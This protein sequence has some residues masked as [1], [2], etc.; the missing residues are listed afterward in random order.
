MCDGKSG[1]K[2]DS[3]QGGVMNSIRALPWKAYFRVAGVVGL[4]TLLALV[5]AYLLGMIFY[6]GPFAQAGWENGLLGLMWLVAMVL[7]FFRIKVW[8]VRVVWWL[9]GLAVV[10]AP[11]LMIRPSNDRNW[12]PE[13]DRTGYASVKGDVVTL[14]NVRNFVHRGREDF[15]E[16]WEVRK[17]HL[18]KLRGL[19]YF[20]SNF[21]GDTLAHPILSFDFGEDGRVC[22][23]VETR[24]EVGEKFTPFG[25]LY[26]MF[27]LQYLFIT[28][29]DCIPLRTNVRGEIVRRYT[30][31]GSLEKIRAMFLSSVKIQNDLAERPRFYNVIRANCTTSLRAQRPKSDRGPLDS[32]LLFNGMLDEYL[33]EQNLLKTE[34]LSFEK[35]RERSIVNKVAQEIQATPDFSNRIRGGDR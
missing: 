1:E 5:A 9:A 33:Y 16:R 3:H 22:L 27:E 7:V 11:W 21:Y 28:E 31:N 35:L 6:N 29:E 20:Q 24:R 23:S 17:V 32:R 26:K 30:I 19:D 14:Y 15:D 12:E 18:S 2:G 4:C 34:G 13:F 10:L 25:G 8:K